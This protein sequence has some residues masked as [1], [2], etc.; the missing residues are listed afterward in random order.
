LGRLC[1][2]GH[3]VQGR[4][5]G[6][7]LRARQWQTKKQEEKV[8]PRKKLTVAQKYNQLK[9]QTERAGMT[10]KEKDGKIVVSRKT[11]RKK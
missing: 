9:K 11:K 2:E 8:M 10:V 7:Q 1:H 3:E 6:A 5:K 4:K